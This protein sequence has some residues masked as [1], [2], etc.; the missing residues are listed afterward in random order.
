MK[1]VIIIFMN[2]LFVMV[3]SADIISVKYECETNIPKVTKSAYQEIQAQIDSPLKTAD[4]SQ[5]YG[6]KL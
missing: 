2:I 5:S 1:N 6:Y 4:M 3:V